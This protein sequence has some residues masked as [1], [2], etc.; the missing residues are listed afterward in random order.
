MYYKIHDLG[1]LASCDNLDKIVPILNELEIEDVVETRTNVLREFLG[2]DQSFSISD[3][4][5]TPEQEY[6][7]A[8][9][10]LVMMNK[11]K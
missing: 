8:K 10:Q 7:I 5:L 11:N 1:K 6:E 9:Q 3:D 2:I 4:D